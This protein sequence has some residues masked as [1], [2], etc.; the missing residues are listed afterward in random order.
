MEKVVQAIVID[1][2]HKGH[3][4]QLPYHPTIRL[5]KPRTIMVD[6]CCDDMEM[7]PNNE[8]VIEYKECFRAVDGEVVLYSTTGVIRRTSKG[9]FQQN[10]AWL[11]GHTT[12]PFTLAITTAS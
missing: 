2:F 7:P 9:S 5:L 10:S 4:V 11:P 12:P 3:V 8:E 1:G 6:T